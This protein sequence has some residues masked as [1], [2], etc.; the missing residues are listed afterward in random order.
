MLRDLKQYS[1]SGGMAPEA[2]QS[3]SPAGVGGERRQSVKFEYG[4]I[5]VNVNAAPGQSEEEIARHVRRE[6]F[7]ALGGLAE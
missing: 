3:S 2:R 6:L 5:Q 7:I 4:A 1:T